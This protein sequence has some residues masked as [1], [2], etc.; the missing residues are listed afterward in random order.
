MSAGFTDV[1]NPTD[2]L[3]DYRATVRELCGNLQRLKELLEIQ[4]LLE[5]PPASRLRAHCES[6]DPPITLAST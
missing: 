4:I 5:S 3:E 2:M 1:A 6:S